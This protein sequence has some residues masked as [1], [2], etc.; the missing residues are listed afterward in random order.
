MAQMDE[1]QFRK[2]LEMLKKGYVPMNFAEVEQ[3]TSG[4]LL[5]F[6]DYAAALSECVKRQNNNIK[7]LREMNRQ[8]DENL[9]KV[10]ALLARY[11]TEK[12]DIQ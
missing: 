3:H 5:E 9:K 1:K 2:S 8:L 10:R 11:E 4:T 7:L 12:E 6:S